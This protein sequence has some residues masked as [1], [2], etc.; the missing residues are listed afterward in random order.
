MQLD[1]V[2]VEV[3]ARELREEGLT[4]AQYQLLVALAGRPDVQ[5]Q[6]L[7]AMLAVTKGNVSMLVARLESAG[8]VA[9]T[10]SGAANLL[11]LTPEG[12]ATV[13]RL[14]PRH[15]AFLAERFADLSDADLAELGR[16]LDVLE[17]RSL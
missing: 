11:R 9:R 4:P 7:G 2:L 15:A 1:E 10:P 12:E 14:R 6:E 5:Q 17:R 13:A 8:L 3:A 16:L